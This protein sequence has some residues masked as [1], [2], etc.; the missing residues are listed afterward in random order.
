MSGDHKHKRQPNIFIFNEHD[1]LV[2]LNRGQRIHHEHNFEEKKSSSS[3]THKSSSSSTRSHRS[4]SS[5][6]FGPTGPEGPAGPTGPCCG[7]TVLFWNSGNAT[8]N[9]DLPF[10]GWGNTSS[11]SLPSSI[12]V[13]YSGTL[14]NLY[15]LVPGNSGCTGTVTVYVNGIATSLT[16]TGNSTTFN[17]TVDSVSVNAG[18][19]VSIH[20]V[21]T[22]QCQ[23]NVIASVE[24]DA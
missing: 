12:I 11:T 10:I 16:A 19:L 7:K 4:S 13:P 1:D 20:C 2:V 6:S 24:L 9:N 8:P 15:A 17:D 5:F 22:G 3:T 21:I 18:D 14:T 23:T